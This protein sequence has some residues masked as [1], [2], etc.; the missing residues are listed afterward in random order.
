MLSK[1]YFTIGVAFFMLSACGAATPKVDAK[2]E[3]E[4]TNIALPAA[5]VSTAV[6]DPNRV[7][8]VQRI[9][10]DG[11]VLEARE[12]VGP[13]VQPRGT[14]PIRMDEIREIEAATGRPYQEGDSIHGRSRV[15]RNARPH[16]DDI[17]AAENARINRHVPE[18]QDD[19]D[20]A[21][22]LRLNGGP[23]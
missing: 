4:T 5:A 21:E 19:V 11:R 3:A 10:K 12:L 7:A 17:D 6:E 1:K 22:N 9:D 15:S 18:H 20:A 14:R 23:E 8:T 13:E 2:T 16:Q